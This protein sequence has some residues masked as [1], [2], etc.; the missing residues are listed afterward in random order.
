[1]KTMK[2]SNNLQFTFQEI[3]N[4]HEIASRRNI[5]YRITFKAN[6][7]QYIGITSQ[8]FITRIKEHKRKKDNLLL[9]NAISKHGF[10]NILW[11]IIDDAKTFDQLKKLEIKYIK[12]FKTKKPNGYNLTDGGDGTIG[13]T[14]SPEWIEKNKK[15]RKAYFKDPKNREKQSI[16]NKQAHHRN[17]QQAEEHS[18][19][20]KHRMEDP[21]VI[22]EIQK[23]Q[24]KYHERPGIKEVHAL[25]RGAKFFNVYKGNEHIE[26]YLV[27]SQCARELNLDKAKINACLHNKRKSHKGY[28]FIFVDEEKD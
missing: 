3:E 9:S 8:T 23:Q 12:I 15:R 18:L 2:K 16:A 6:D 25:Q 20:M 22:E 26:T 28:K 21:A 27:Q 17:P 1:M 11:E 5:V 7:K 10:D 13:Y 4:S 24:K 19:F 14:A